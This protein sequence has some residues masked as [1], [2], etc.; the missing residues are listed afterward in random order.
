MKIVIKIGKWLFALALVVY[1]GI[2]AYLYFQQQAI[3]FHPTK[4]ASGFRFDFDADFEE[5]FIIGADGTKLNGVLF[6]SEESKGLVF[7]LHGN[8]GDIRRCEND[9]LVYTELGYDCFVLDYRGFGKSEGEIISEDQFY[10]DV[11]IAYDSLCAHYN[12]NDV[13]ILGYSVGTASA[14][15]LASKSNAKH[16]VL[17]APYYSMTDMMNIQY[18]FILDYFLEYK[19]STY[20]FIPQ[21]NSSISIFHGDLDEVIYYGSSIKLKKHFKRSDELIMLEGQKH[22]GMNFNPVYKEWLRNKF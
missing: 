14:A 7:Y 15:M 9:A 4:L 17:L 1:I 12:E 2:S 6:K 5:K 22:G 16:L 18:P 20:E 8:T 19:F 11:E 10:S 3:L 21:V 13:I